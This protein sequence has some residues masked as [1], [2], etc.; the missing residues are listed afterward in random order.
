VIDFQISVFSFN[1]T[2]SNFELVEA[3]IS[4]S[5]DAGEIYNGYL[6][7]IVNIVKVNDG[8]AAYTILVSKNGYQNE[9]ITYLHDDL[10]AL[11]T[12][13]EIYLSEGITNFSCGDQ[14]VDPRDGQAY[15]TVQIGTQCWMAENLNIGSMVNYQESTLFVDNQ[16]DNGTIEKWCGNNDPLYCDEHGGFY[17]WS[18]MMNYGTIDN[19]L[20]STTQGICPD[21]WHVPSD[22]EWKVLE[23]HLGITR[24]QAD[25][26]YDRGSDQGNQLKEIGITH[27]RHAYGN[28]SSGFTALGS[29][30]AHPEYGAPHYFKSFA[31]FWS[32]SSP[33]EY[34]QYSDHL[35]YRM[36]QDSYGTVYRFWENTPDYYG[37]SVRCVQN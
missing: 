37:F 32:T 13:I 28:N 19:G 3:N 9:S 33:V 6:N 29:G 11:T 30:Y 23:M 25:A 2:I 21:G 36:I 20:V 35:V 31:A 10:I 27:W 26:S 22:E 17:Q 5:G 18:E 4:I 16:T 8:H 34:P 15:N 24:T 1:T 7:P 14:L 12:P